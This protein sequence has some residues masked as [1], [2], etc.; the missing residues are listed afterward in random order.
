MKRNGRND[1]DD[2]DDRDERERERERKTIHLVTH[3]HPPVNVGL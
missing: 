2:R 1:R 3:S